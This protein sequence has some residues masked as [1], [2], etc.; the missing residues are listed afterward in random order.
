MANIFT[1][2]ADQTATPFELSAVLELFSPDDR[3]RPIPPKGTSFGIKL[4]TT[5]IPAD[6]GPLINEHFG[7]KF[8]FALVPISEINPYTHA[9]LL[10]LECRPKKEI[11]DGT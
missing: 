9:G 3:F 10:Y 1:E 7:E 6:V 11:K 4:A 5:D 2:T 8:S